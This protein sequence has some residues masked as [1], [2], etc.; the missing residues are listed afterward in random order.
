VSD[1]FL[2]D[3]QNLI[4]VTIVTCLNAAAYCSRIKYTSNASK[5]QRC[6]R[7]IKRTLKVVAALNAN[8]VHRQK[9]V[10]SGK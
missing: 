7:D 8:L 5:F 3:S 10:I 1:I 4:V 6:I 9:V 2:H